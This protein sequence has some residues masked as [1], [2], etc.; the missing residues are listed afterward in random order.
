[1][2]SSLAGIDDSIDERTV[3]DGRCVDEVADFCSSLRD[4]N[5]IDVEASYFLYGRHANSSTE[6][7]NLLC[8]C[9]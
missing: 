2:R 3:D 1:M 4:V 9:I 6:S 5:S 7:E 8:T